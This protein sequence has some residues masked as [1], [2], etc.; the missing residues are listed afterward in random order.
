[1]FISA[2]S[3]VAPAPTC[4]PPVFYHGTVN[5]FEEFEPGHSNGF[6]RPRDGFYFTDD[7]AIAEELGHIVKEAHLHMKRPLD[8]RDSFGTAADFATVVAALPDEPRLK[9]SEHSVYGAVVRGLTQTRE[10]IQALCSTGFDSLI[11]PDQLGGG[12]CF[13]SFIVFDPRQIEMIKK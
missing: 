12:P 4:L 5:V 7:R 2:S 3:D 10:F 1:V 11:I 9:I 8:L 6:S 13:D